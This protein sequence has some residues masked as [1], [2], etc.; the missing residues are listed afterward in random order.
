MSKSQ[1][2]KYFLNNPNNI[3]VPL[4]RD[5]LHKALSQQEF[6]VEIPVAD[7]EVIEITEDSSTAKLKKVCVHELNYCDEKSQV[8]RIWKI[9]LEKNIPGISTSSKTT[10]CAILVL[11]KYES[12]HRLNI[13]LIELKS[14][15]DN[16][17]LE[18]IEEKFSS[19]MSRVCM[20]LVLNNHLNLKQGYN[21]EEIYLDFKG[22]LFYKTFSEK[23]KLEGDRNSQLYLILKNYNKS[24]IL[25]CQTILTDQ[26]K[27]KVQCFCH[28][29]NDLET[30]IRRK[31]KDLL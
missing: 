27:I 10:E 31:L 3:N 4:L 14:S 8:E 29:D 16:K 21:E 19:A 17:E 15:I 30:E 18:K 6:I 11:Q 9:N 24:G 23:R 7:D 5:E 25:T 28:Q 2:N 26:D 13:I 22:I 20:L 12:S 1:K